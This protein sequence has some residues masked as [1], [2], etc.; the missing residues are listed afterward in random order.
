M[1]IYRKGHSGVSANKRSQE[2]SQLC[3]CVPP[4]TTSFLNMPLAS[5]ASPTLLFT[6]HHPLPTPGQTLQ[7]PCGSRVSTHPD[8][9]APTRQRPSH[10][11][12]CCPS[13]P[14]E[15]SPEGWPCLRAGQGGQSRLPR[16]LPGGQLD[17][18]PGPR[19]Q[20][21]TLP[22][23]QRHS[24]P[25]STTYQRLDKLPEPSFFSPIKWA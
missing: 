22:G 8:S 6:H 19:C 10:S 11:C 16:G 18:C 9:L 17:G 13:D 12:R 1:F 25:S 3:N 20:H 15:K 7:L 4:L 2:P 5:W 21:V 24:N 14:L 23:K